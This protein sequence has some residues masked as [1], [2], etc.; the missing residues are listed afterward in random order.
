[1]PI[2]GE[3]DHVCPVCAT[4]KTSD[5]YGVRFDNCMGFLTPSIVPKCYVRDFS[6]R[7]EENR[8]FTDSVSPGI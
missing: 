1:M 5:L 2:L 7:A 3:I 4:L 8:D 6:I